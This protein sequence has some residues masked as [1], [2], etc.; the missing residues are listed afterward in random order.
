VTASCELK[1]QGLPYPRTCPECGLGPCKREG[2]RLQYTGVIEV[3]DNKGEVI[4]PVM[5][6]GKPYLVLP[7]GTVIEK[8]TLRG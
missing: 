4:P 2:L 5:I 1:E 8:I 3:L 6:A 7:V